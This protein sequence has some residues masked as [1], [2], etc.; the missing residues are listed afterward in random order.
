MQIKESVFG[1]MSDVELI[2]QIVGTLKALIFIDPVEADRRIAKIEMMPR[3]GLLKLMRILAD[4]FNRQDK[5]LKILS[6]RDHKFPS[7]L[8]VMVYGEEMK[9]I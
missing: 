8:N 9:Q 4:G 6:S 3:K 1:G 2:R 5:F 7:T